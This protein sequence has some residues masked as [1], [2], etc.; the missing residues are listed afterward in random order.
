VNQTKYPLRI[1]VGFLLNQPIGYNRDIH[2]EYPE[3]VLKPDFK[4]TEFMGVARVSRTPQGIFVQGNFQGR[5]PAECVRC[6]TDFDQPLQATFDELYA[7]DKRSITESGLILPDDANIDLEPLAREYLMI[8]VP[9][10]TVCKED[11]LGLCTICGA[12]LNE[13]PKEHN[14]PEEE[15]DI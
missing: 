6:L 15:T 11:C 8:E 3:I 9:I 14:H 7:F 12:N 10:N 4:L 2:F 13:E 1:N 5:A